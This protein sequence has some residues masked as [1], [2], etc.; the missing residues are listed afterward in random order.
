[1]STMMKFFLLAGLPGLASAGV[2]TPANPQ[3]EAPIAGVRYLLE[4]GST[5]EFDST[6]KANRN[7]V[8]NGWVQELGDWIGTSPSVF[9]PGMFTY[10]VENEEYNRTKNNGDVVKV[11]H[12]P[13]SEISF[14]TGPTDPF[15]QDLDLDPDCDCG[16]EDIAAA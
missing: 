13:V 15:I 5:T 8:E 2:K 6:L 11:S 3:L 14:F 4:K 7:R 12:T 10:T 9:K 1:M 16:Y